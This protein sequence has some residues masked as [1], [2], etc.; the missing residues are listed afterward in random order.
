MFENACIDFADLVLK[1]II[2][3]PIK[4]CPSCRKS[5]GSK[6]EL[7][8]DQNS[9]SI[10]KKVF[11]NLTEYLEMQEKE[12]KRVVHQIY[13]SR[14]GFKSKKN[15]PITRTNLGRNYSTT[16]SNEAGTN[17][18]DPIDLEID[19]IQEKRRKRIR[20]NPKVETSHNFETAPVISDIPSSAIVNEIPHTQYSGQKGNNS[21]EDPLSLL[22]TDEKTMENLKHLLMMENF[23]NYLKNLE[24]ALSFKVEPHP[25]DSILPPLPYEIFRTSSTITIYQ[26]SKVICKKLNFNEKKYWDKITLYIKINDKYEPLNRENM[27]LSD[28]NNL[29]WKDFKD[30][31][32]YETESSIDEILT[33]GYKSMDTNRVLYYSINFEDFL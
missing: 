25:Q 7:R 24:F 13:E 19:E 21:K 32:L 31:S 6:R 22:C 1:K 33:R 29:Y 5:I 20:V 9:V 23:E 4:T 15:K 27:V 3:G 11:K 2:R 12:E 8:N 10:M 18:E 16:K 14:L 28:I 17:P 26:I 30:I